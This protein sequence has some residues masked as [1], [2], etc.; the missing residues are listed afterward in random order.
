MCTQ[1]YVIRLYGKMAELTVHSVIRGY[2][3]IKIKGIQAL[4]QCL[5]TKI[6]DFNQ[7]DGC[8]NTETPRPSPLQLLSEQAVSHAIGLHVHV[9][10]VS[11]LEGYCRIWNLI[12]KII[13]DKLLESIKL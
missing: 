13:D 11:E 10:C 7:H 9:V 6:D 3:F 4:A 5:K 8:I 2:R 1:D 12:I